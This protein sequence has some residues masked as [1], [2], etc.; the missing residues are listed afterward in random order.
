[1]ASAILLL[2]LLTELRS[3]ETLHAENTRQ[4]SQRFD[5]NFVL[6]S[7]AHLAFTGKIQKVI[8]D[9]LFFCTL[10]LSFLL[11]THPLVQCVGFILHVSIRN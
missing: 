4:M 8:P 10:N 9:V 7:N 6:L 3:N 1:M 11:P 2:R 5:E